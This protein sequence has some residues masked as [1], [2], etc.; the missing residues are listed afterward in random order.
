MYDQEWNEEELNEISATGEGF[1]RMNG[2]KET[3]KDAR[4]VRRSGERDGGF[5][6]LVGYKEELITGR[7]KK[8]KDCKS[9]NRT[10][11]EARDRERWM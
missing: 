9:W 11:E 10:K 5:C 8:R 6:E 4:E 7:C 3:K 1:A 2:D